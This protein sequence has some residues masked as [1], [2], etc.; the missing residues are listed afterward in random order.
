M[1][2][3]EDIIGFEGLYKVSNL[4]N[5]MSIRRNK[6]LSKMIDN[7][8]YHVVR[9]SNKGTFKTFKVHR[10]VAKVFL[11]NYSENLQVNH[12]NEIKTDNQV[13]NLEMC[14][15]KYNC[16]YGSRRTV[17]A[18]PVIQETLNGEFV[19]EWESAQEIERKL[20]YCRQV[21]SSCCKGYQVDNHLNRGNKIYPVHKAYNYKWR[22]KDDK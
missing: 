6:L 2:Q 18:R 1:E 3:W 22:Y 12:K 20:G 5:V 17:L 7:Y 16:N 4:G 9:L 8:G 21:I 14:D 13:S 10:L 15:N 11:D 19:K